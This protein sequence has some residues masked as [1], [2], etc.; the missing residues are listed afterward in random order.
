MQKLEGTIG[1]APPSM[2]KRNTGM[3]NAGCVC[4]PQAPGEGNGGAALPSRFGIASLPVKSQLRQQAM[5]RR[6]RVLDF[7]CGGT[8]PTPRLLQSF[9]SR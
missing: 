3:A 6:V 9:L 2:Q 5:L 4:L 1:S 7:Q 8:M